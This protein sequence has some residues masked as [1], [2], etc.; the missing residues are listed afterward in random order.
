MFICF[1]QVNG[2]IFG[3]HTLH[4]LYESRRSE[5]IRSRICWFRTEDRRSSFMTDPRRGNR[6]EVESHRGKLYVTKYD[7]RGTLVWPNTRTS[8]YF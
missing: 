1:E 3:S 6:R 4:P 5:D 8:S 2:V 7:T